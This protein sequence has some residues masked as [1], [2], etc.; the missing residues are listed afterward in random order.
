MA[1][2][3]TPRLVADMFLPEQI[4][5]IVDAILA[6]VGYGVASESGADRL[7]ILAAGFR[8]GL[9]DLQIDCRKH[10]VKAVVSEN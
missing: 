8:S 6:I 1:E 2:D 10:R 5:I 4:D 9:S 7:S 3:D